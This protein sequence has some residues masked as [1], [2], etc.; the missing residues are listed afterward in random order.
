MRTPTVIKVSK[1]SYGYVI[2]IN[3]SGRGF[4]SVLGSHHPSVAAEAAVRVWKDYGDEAVGLTV[5]VP[6]EV[7]ATIAER[8]GIPWRKT[9][10]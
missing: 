4:T 9:P 2:Y 10:L 7:E 1:H 6:P 3:G 5:E 8:G